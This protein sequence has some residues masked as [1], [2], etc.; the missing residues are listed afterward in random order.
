MHSLIPQKGV[1]TGLEP[2]VLTL[3]P[4]TQTSAMVR[5]A[6]KVEVRV[7]NFIM[8]LNNYMYIYLVICPD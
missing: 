3:S 4:Y 1:G 7:T 5:S 2:T 8:F 6:K